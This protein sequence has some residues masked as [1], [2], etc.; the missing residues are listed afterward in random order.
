MEDYLDITPS[1]LEEKISVKL[2][3]DAESESPRASF[4]H[5]GTLFY[6]GRDFDL[7]DKGAHLPMTGTYSTSR[8]DIELSARYVELQGGVALGVQI[9]DYGSS[10]ARAYAVDELEIANGLLWIDKE[11]IEKEWT[12]HGTPDPKTAALNCLKS[13]AEELDQYL[14]GD[15]FGYV[16]ET[17]D[18][19]R[20]MDSCWGFYG[21]KYATEAAHEAAIHAAN[22]LASE[23][24]SHAAARAWAFSILFGKETV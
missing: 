19:D 4:D 23:I 18:G 12:A 6:E 20:H 10:G 15:V 5:A 16:I 9:Q 7:S 14:S 24:K 11:T 2:Y 3:V 17:A 13:E 22:E 1:E 8:S 21:Q